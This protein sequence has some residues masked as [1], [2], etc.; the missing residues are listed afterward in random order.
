MENRYELKI[1]VPGEKVSR[2]VKWTGKDG[3]DACTRYAD[4]NRGHEVR[5]WR[6]APCLYVGPVAR[7]CIIG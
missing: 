2:T 7:G 3:M 6:E 4:A 5:A 1:R